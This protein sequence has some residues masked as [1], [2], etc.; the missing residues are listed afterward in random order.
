[1]LG[2][3]V[4]DICASPW[5]GG[6]CERKHFELFGAY[7]GA[8]DDTICTVAIADALLRSRDYA[9]TLREWVLRYPGRGYGGLFRNW[10]VSLQG[11]YNSYGNGGA[12]RVSPTALLATSLIEAEQL[13]VATA[14]ITHNH[15]D[16]VKGAQAVSVAIWLARQG[17]LP[18]TIRGELQRRYAYDLG[19]SVSELERAGLGFSTLAEET[20]PTALICALESEEYAQAI[21]SAVAIGGD[22]D[23]IACMAG[24]IAEALHGLPQDVAQKSLEYLT[25]EMVEVLTRLYERAG[26][27]CPWLE[28][29]VKP[30]VPASPTVEPPAQE[31]GPWWKR[32]F[33]SR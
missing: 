10:A 31:P 14:E 3:I 28:N 27:P 21:K 26:V 16:G 22:T 29:T 24:G 15:P 11:P 4:G 5:E 17:E 9:Q 7:A 23:T 32:F 25:S 20:V 12:M 1:M 33:A 6:S 19:P 30:K 2:A 13:A 18:M 8:T